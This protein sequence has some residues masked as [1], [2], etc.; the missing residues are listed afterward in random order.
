MS[1]S[2]VVEGKVVGQRRPLFT[3]WQVDLPPLDEN[4][5][6]HLK[7]RDLLASIVIKEVV[8]FRLRQEELK[9]A[10]VMSQQQIEQGVS[11][12]K[13][14][15]GERDI[16]QEVN[17]DEAPAVALQAFEDGLYFVFIDDVQQTHLDSEVF[18]RTNSKVMFLRLTALVGG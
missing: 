18:L 9:L 6:D 17:V 7:L 13:V 8:A 10:R 5:G 15:P 2:I 3:D 11:G 16:Q 4:R 1:V 12:G 14:D